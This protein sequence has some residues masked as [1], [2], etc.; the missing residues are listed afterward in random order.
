MRIEVTRIDATVSAQISGLES[1]DSDLTRSIEGVLSSVTS[2]EAEMGRLADR[3]LLLEQNSVLSKLKTRVGTMD[4]R[5]QELAAS[6]EEAKSM[7][8]TARSMA[9]ESTMQSETRTRRLQ[10]RSPWT[11]SR[12][13]FRTRSMRRLP[14]RRRASRRTSR[15]SNA[16]SR[17]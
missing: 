12:P 2:L 11:C 9:E 4:H 17:I 15:R 7:A 8:E 14:R 3:V 13:S 10:A 16:S 1:S 6:V 5:I